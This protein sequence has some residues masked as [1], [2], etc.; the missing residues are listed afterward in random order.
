MST[1][2][3]QKRNIQTSKFER[4]LSIIVITIITLGIVGVAAYFIGVEIANAKPKKDEIKEKF[5]KNYN[6]YNIT[7]ADLGILLKEDSDWDTTSNKEI[8]KKQTLDKNCHIIA[9]DSTKIK[10]DFRKRVNDFIDEKVKDDKPFGILMF[11]LSKEE[12]KK[13]LEKNPTEDKYKILEFMHTDE[14]GFKDSELPN[15]ILLITETNRT[16]KKTPER[17]IT[18]QNKILEKLKVDKK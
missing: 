12:N 16:F 7:L 4:I 13:I 8:I 18:D 1:E 11:D 2:N 5:E 10:N 6:K 3:K 15:L 17:V 14:F 9:F